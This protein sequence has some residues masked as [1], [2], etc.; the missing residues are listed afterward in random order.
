[1]ILELIIDEQGKVA[2]ADVVRSVPPFD[3]AALSAAR[4]W[5]YEVTQVDGQPSA[6]G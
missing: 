4:Q 2:T 6:C 3:E 5:E 1:M